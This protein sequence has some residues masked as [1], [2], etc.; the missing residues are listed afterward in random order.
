MWRDTAH[1]PGI[2]REGPYCNINLQGIYSQS[3]NRYMQANN[4]ILRLTQQNFWLQSV[5]L[6][7]RFQY[8][9]QETEA[10]GIYKRD[11]F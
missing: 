10:P 4:M 9:H 8:F 3:L 6:L 2:D 7:I 5:I 11:I 1:F